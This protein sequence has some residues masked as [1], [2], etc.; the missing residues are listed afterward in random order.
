VHPFLKAAE[1]PD[2]RLFISHRMIFCLGHGSCRILLPWLMPPTLD[3]TKS[4]LIIYRDC[5]SWS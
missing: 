2:R 4:T 1:V 3:R 5:S